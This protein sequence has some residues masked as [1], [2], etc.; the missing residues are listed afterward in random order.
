MKRLAL[1]IAVVIGI[2]VLAVALY[3]GATF[4]AV[5]AAR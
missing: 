1:N 3:F 5:V 4:I 2:G